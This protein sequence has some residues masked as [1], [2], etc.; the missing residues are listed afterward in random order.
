MQE[1][2]ASVKKCKETKESFSCYVSENEKNG[3]FP[4]DERLSAIEMTLMFRRFPPL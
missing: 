1:K 3:D 2:E 4:P